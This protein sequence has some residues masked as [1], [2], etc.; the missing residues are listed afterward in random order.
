MK[1]GTHLILSFCYL[2]HDVYVY[3][4]PIINPTNFMFEKY[5]SISKSK[6]EI[7]SEVTRQILCEISGFDKSER[8]FRD[9]LEYI[10][11]ILGKQIIN[12]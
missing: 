12:T 2:Y 8:T 7:Y 9:S 10:S 11:K 1:L 4:L 6:W 3:K 5:N